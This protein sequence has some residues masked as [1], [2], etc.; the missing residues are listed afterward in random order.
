MASGKVNEHGRCAG[1]RSDRTPLC[2]VLR[3]PETVIHHDIVPSP[4]LLPQ[5]GSYIFED[6][7]LKGGEDAPGKSTP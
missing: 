2:P 1:I 7:A 5:I 3:R 4:E 6:G